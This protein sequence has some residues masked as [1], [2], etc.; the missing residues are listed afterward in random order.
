LSEIESRKKKKN[1]TIDNTLILE[2][3][4]VG[5]MSFLGTFGGERL[6]AVRTEQHCWDVRRGRVVFGRGW[7]HV[8]RWWWFKFKRETMGKAL[9]CHF[10]FFYF[11]I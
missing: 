3:M 11:Q 7:Y 4:K 9:T 6:R 2:T 5:H 10:Y 1:Y 8:V